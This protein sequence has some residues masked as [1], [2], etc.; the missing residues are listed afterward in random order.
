M[1]KDEFIR[2]YVKKVEEMTGDRVD[3]VTNNE[4]YSALANLVMDEIGTTWAKSHQ[5]DPDQ[6]NKEVYYFSIEYLIGRLLRTYLHNLGLAKIAIEGLKELNIDF[7]EIEKCEKDAGLG[8][9]GLGRLAAC[10]LDSMASQ[11]IRGNG[12]GIRYKY[13]LFEQRIVDGNQV[14]LPDQWMAIDYPWEIK[15]AAYA[16]VVKFKGDV[17]TELIDGEWTFIH[18]NYEPI[19]AVPYDIPVKGYKNNTVNRLRIYSAEPVQV[20]DLNTFNSGDFTKALEFRSQAEAI[21]QILYPN[22]QSCQG[23]ELRLKQQYFFVCAG[24]KNIIGKYRSAHNNSLKNIEECISVHINDT[25]PALCVP[26]FMRILIDE[27]GMPWDES[28]ELTQNIMSYTNHT[29]MP[30]ALETWSVELMKYLLPR[31]YMIIEEINR[32]FLKEQSLLYPDDESLTNEMSIIKFNQVHMA[33]LAIIGSHSVNGVAELHSEILKKETFNPFYQRFPNKFTNVTN[34]VSHRR[35]LIKANPKL[36]ELITESIGEEWIKTPS[37][38]NNLSS[39]KND[40]IFLEQL[41]KIKKSNKQ[42][43][44]NYIKNSTGLEVNADSIF[45]IHVKRIHQYKRQLLNVLHIMDLYNRLKANPHMEVSP[46]TFIFAGKAAPGYYYAKQVIKLIN[47][48]ARKVNNDIQTRDYLKVVFLE[49]FNVSLAEMIYPAADVSEQISTAGTEASGTG[50]MKFMMNGAVTLGTMDG[51]NIEIFELVNQANIFIFGLTADEVAEYR[52]NNNYSS[53]D[54]YNG[55]PRVK[56]VLD[57][58][59]NGYLDEVPQEFQNIY[60]NLLLYNDN[61]FVLKDFDSYVNA[62][63]IISETYKNQN[64]WLHMS[65]NNITHS[66]K[67]SSDRSICDYAHNIWNLCNEKGQKIEK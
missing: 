31:I 57:E 66:G 59:I 51:A 65:L 34:G 61:Y 4:L 37:Q 35:F 16:V 15:K 29:V 45:D 32:R 43:L 60:D 17:R 11:G 23:K 54:I 8:N 38:L 46:R 42:C 67:F 19:L 52:R 41:S 1:T 26:E 6:G 5:R 3:S 30:E 21:T 55:D 20:F 25:H 64:H 9:G 48:V 63:N 28:W 47:S 27:E 33:N 2:Q 12:V 44:A 40:P 7:Y 18:E 36:T 62:Q 58:L 10:F 22:D 56:Q 50:N 24:L 14:E 13:G 39:Y 49:N 53:I